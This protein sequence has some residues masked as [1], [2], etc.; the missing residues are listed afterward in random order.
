MFGD[1]LEHWYVMNLYT[2]IGKNAS[3]HYERIHKILHV[4]YMIL[5]PEVLVSICDCKLCCNVSLFLHCWSL[6]NISVMGLCRV[7][8]NG[9]T[10]WTCLPLVQPLPGSWDWFILFSVIIYRMHD[11]VIVSYHDKS[12]T[13]KS[14]YLPGIHS[15]FYP[16]PFLDDS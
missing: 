13:F 1:F 10:E 7:Q 2:Y 8:W 3:M 4:F 11:C 14:L 15:L 9:Q 16:L 5:S 12:R 6:L